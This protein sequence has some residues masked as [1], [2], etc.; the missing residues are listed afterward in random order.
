MDSLSREPIIYSRVI[1]IAASR[2]AA[3][4]RRILEGT[5]IN[6]QSLKQLDAGVTVDDYR[7]LLHNAKAVP[8]VRPFCW[9]L[10]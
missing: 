3:D 8:A 1:T 6:K 9:R 5:R 7:R 2:N 4:T 10:A